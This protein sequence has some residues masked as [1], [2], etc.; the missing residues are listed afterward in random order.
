MF[1]HILLA[2]SQGRMVS[3]VTRLLAAHPR[4][5]SSFP[6]KA[7]NRFFAQ[8]SIL[9]GAHA[10]FCSVETRGKVAKT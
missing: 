4:S 8:T 6:S 9:V 5:H 7:R 3:I 2:R 1:V 10:A